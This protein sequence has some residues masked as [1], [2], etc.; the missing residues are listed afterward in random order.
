MDYLEIKNQ[1]HENHTYDSLVQSHRSVLQLFCFHMCLLGVPFVSTL[2]N[3]IEGTI[4]MIRNMQQ[5][6]H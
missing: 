2:H 6:V 5:M 3:Q 4:L 1:N